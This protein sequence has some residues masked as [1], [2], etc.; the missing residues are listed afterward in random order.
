[1]SITPS[2]NQGYGDVRVVIMSAIRLDTGDLVAESA[3][4]TVLAGLRPH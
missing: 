1:M 4:V 2:A 3:L